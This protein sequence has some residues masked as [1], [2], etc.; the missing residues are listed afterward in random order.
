MLDMMVGV[1][2][3]SATITGVWLLRWNT[4]CGKSLKHFNYLHV[5][6]GLAIC[7]SYVG[8]FTLPK[9]FA[10][11]IKDQCRAIAEMLS[12][13]ADIWEFIW[14]TGKYLFDKLGIV[15]DNYDDPLPKLGT[16][17][18]PKKGMKWMV[19]SRCS[20]YPSKMFTVP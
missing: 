3:V 14:F 2:C 4:V 11:C 18:L 17:M 10:K 8:E 9:V 19:G 1:C 6:I 5:C 12:E 20:G 7:L 15:E 13:M 16:L